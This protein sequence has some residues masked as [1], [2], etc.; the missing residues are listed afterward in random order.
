MSFDKQANFEAGVL[1]CKAMLE[2]N[3]LPF[4]KFIDA[5]HSKRMYGWYTLNRVYVNV[6]KSRPATITPGYSWTYPG[7]KA[8]LTASGVAAHEVGHHVVHH[9]KVNTPYFHEAQVSSYEPSREE[10]FS[11]MM[12]LFITNPDLLR[13]GRP[14]RWAFLTK[15]LGL[16]ASSSDAWITVLKDAHPK[17]IHAAERW[18]ALGQNQAGMSTK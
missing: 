2:L 10:C 11:E 14:Q 18:I 4:P 9:L 5:S 13:T 6:K 1:R 3:K 15:E 17:I 16:K 12:K 7:Y 8:D